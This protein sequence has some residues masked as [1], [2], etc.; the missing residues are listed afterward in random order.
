MRID[1]FGW[2][3]ASA[4]ALFAAVSAA[5]PAMMLRP[6][7]P[8]RPAVS[9]APAQPAEPSPPA[10][11]EPTAGPAAVPVRVPPE[12]AIEQATIP[13]EAFLQPPDTG[14]ERHERL[15]W[16]THVLPELCGID[17]A[18]NAAIMLGGHILAHHHPGRAKGYIP[19]D[20]FHETIATYRAG[21]AARFMRELRT[22][23]DACP[24]N[25]YEGGC[26]QSEVGTYA[27]GRAPAHGDEAIVVRITY[28]QVHNDGPTGR[29][30]SRLYLAVR[31]GDA[32]MVLAQHGYE[33]AVVEPETF[34][35][36][37]RRAVQ[38]LTTWLQR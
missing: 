27:L 29:Q 33:F 2:R 21:G 25:R 9:V 17:F 30:A 3:H 19:N 22:A 15:P 31:I 16:Y 8:A 35:E 14:A 37:G 28:P 11:P 12:A 23:V 38:R 36:I 10:P 7:P 5:V 13:A 20:T 1:G 34:H 18:S 26:H 24:V 32:V 6:D 4:V